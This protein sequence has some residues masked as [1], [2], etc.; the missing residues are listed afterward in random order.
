M[1]EDTKL[2]LKRLAAIFPRKMSNKANLMFSIAQTKIMQK[3]YD[4]ALRQLKEM[5]PEDPD[6]LEIYTLIMKLAVDKMKQ[7]KIA[8][9]VFHTGLLNLTT[10]RDR[11]VLADTYKELMLQPPDESEKGLSKTSNLLTH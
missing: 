6:R 10:Q 3:E 9:N 4:A 7:P 11:T 2:V 1:Q 8:K 5:I